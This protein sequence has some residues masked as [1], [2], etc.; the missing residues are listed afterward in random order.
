MKKQDQNKDLPK[1]EETDE[2]STDELAHK[3]KKINVS[4][5]ILSL[6]NNT[7]IYELG[8]TK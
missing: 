5:A 4:M 6:L 7:K 2:G 1:V 8:G 3:I